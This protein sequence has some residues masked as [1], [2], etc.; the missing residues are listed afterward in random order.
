MGS[1]P[2]LAY[3]R[4]V[5]SMEAKAISS[6][7][8]RLGPAFVQAVEAILNCQGHV[9][10]TAMG[11]PAFVGQKLSATLASVGIPSLFLHPADAA[12]GDIGRVGKDD[13]VIALSNSGVTEELL[14]LLTPLKRLDVILVAL[15]GDRKSPLAKAAHM[16][17]D[18]GRI[19]EA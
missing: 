18:V 7:G 14:R 6:V 19:D 3:A 4:S 1:A 8:R 11:K 12:H 13:L 9:V 5:L 10:V 17:I 2:L 16:I 15:T